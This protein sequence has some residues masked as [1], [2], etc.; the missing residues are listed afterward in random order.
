MSEPLKSYD[1]EFQ[2]S[3]SVNHIIK[4]VGNKPATAAEVM[5]I[6]FKIHSE[7][8]I[9]SSVKTTSKYDAKK[10]LAVKWKTDAEALFDVHKIQAFTKSSNAQPIFHARLF[11]IGLLLLEASLRAQ[12]ESAGLFDK[13]IGGLEEPIKEILS[14]EGLSRYNSPLQEPKTVD[15]LADSVPNWQDDPLKNPE[16][17]LLGRGAFARYLAERLDEIPND[18]DV[19]AYS[20]HIYGPWGAGKSTLLNFLRYELEQKE[21]TDGKKGQGKWLVVEYNAWRQQ[22]IQPPWWSLLDR[23]F[24]STNGSLGFWERIAEYWWRLNTGRL[25]FILPFII[26]AW[27]MVL[28]GFPTLQTKVKDANSTETFGTNAESISKVIALITTI[29]GG[30]VAFNRSLLFGAAQAAK[31]YTES[32]DDPANKIKLR[33]NKLIRRLRPNRVA[34]FI[35]DLDRC[36]ASYV[37]ELLEGIQTLFR[38]ASVVFVIA[39]DRN[40]LNA[41]YEERY[42][43]LKQQIREPGKALG[44]LF[45]EKAFRFSTS[46]PG[47][48]EKLKESY[49][50][51]LLHVKADENLKADISEARSEARKEVSNTKSESAVRDLVKDDS[52]RSFAEQRALREEAVVHLASPEIAQR[53]EHTLKRYAYLLEPNPRAMKLLVNGYSAN[54]AMA[55]L[56]EVE[57]ELHQLA[58][59]TILSS[60]WPLLSDYMVEHPEMLS[61]SNQNRNEIPQHLQLLFE[62][63]A[64]KKILVGDEKDPPLTAETLKQCSQMRS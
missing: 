18:D 32:T 37:V 44:T 29:W 17:D 1:F 52:N 6:I 19:G 47:I 61:K 31:T 20:M 14:D 27:I 43:E 2:N 33:F 26:L 45:L 21:T 24:K 60:R 15:D 62:E 9:G 54:R 64:V 4:E 50:K 35:D 53:I 51:Y 49:W 16:D 5:D 23:I 25:Q 38:E 56:S 8:G 30:I 41:C 55:I 39:A 22:H 34:I 40:W 48:P 28:V 58:L 36:Q 7:F 63:G 3:S 12:L 46:M 59:W 42:S 11:A 13:L 10:Q 57:I